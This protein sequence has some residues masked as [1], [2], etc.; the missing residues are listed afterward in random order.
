MSVP[1]PDRRRDHDGVKF[2]RGRHAECGLTSSAELDTFDSGDDRNPEPSW[3]SELH[4]GR[5]ET[6]KSRATAAPQD[7]RQTLNLIRHSGADLES[8]DIIMDYIVR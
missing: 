8:R 2:D 5:H 3:P 4:T 7:R 6:A 1:R